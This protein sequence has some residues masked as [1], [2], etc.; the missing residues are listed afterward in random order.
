GTHR[1]NPDGTKMLDS[2]GDPIPTYDQQV[3]EGLAHVFTGWD[4]AYDVTGYNPSRLNPWYDTTYAFASSPYTPKRHIPEYINPMLPVAERHFTGTK[5]ILN[6]VV[7]P[8]LTTAAGSPLLPYVTPTSGQIADTNFQALPNAEL[9]ATLD[10][11]FNHPNCGPF[12]CRQL[13]QRLVTSH[14]TDDYV[15]RVASKFENDGSNVRGNMAAVVKQILMDPEARS[16]SSLTAIDGFGKQREPMLRFTAFSR[17]FPSLEYTGTTPVWVNQWKMGQTS[18]TRFSHQEN[19]NQTPMGSPSVFNFF[20]PDYRYPGILADAG[21]TTPEFQLTTDTSVIDQAN[22]LHNALINW[23]SSPAQGLVSFLTSKRD[24]LL[25]LRPWMASTS[26]ANLSG[27]IDELNNRLMAG[28]LPSTG[29]NVYHP[30]GSRSIVNAKQ[31]LIDFIGSKGISAI[32]APGAGNITVTTSTAHGLTNGEKIFFNAD[33]GGSFTPSL[34]AGYPRPSF[35]VTVT[36]ANTFTIPATRAAD[37]P[38]SP[39]NLTNGAI[40]HLPYDTPYDRM[41][42]LLV[43]MVNTPDFII[44]R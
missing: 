20:R 42:Y 29:T 9:D 44:Q 34:H 26:N 38:W 12:I 43:T 25:D 7:L 22:F 31:A 17:A 3:V 36:G 37:P 15:Y 13:I 2:G 16:G 8:G 4:Y 14:P 35:T 32:S 5:R 19:I 21:L 40:S 10:A 39:L 30:A 6:N 33:V 23:G 1:L 27:L 28:Q 41:V 24:I 18:F 11:I